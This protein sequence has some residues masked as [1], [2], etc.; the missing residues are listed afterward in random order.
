MLKFVRT[1]SWRWIAGEQ[2]GAVRLGDTLC[3]QE[4]HRVGRGMEQRDQQLGVLNLLSVFSGLMGENTPPSQ[5]GIPH[6]S[7]SGSG[8]H[9]QLTDSEPLVPWARACRTQALIPLP[10]AVDV[11]KKMPV[12][13]CQSRT[14]ASGRPSIC[15]AQALVHVFRHECILLAG[16][17]WHGLAVL[18]HA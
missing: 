13:M 2:L 6:I 5:R 10:K 15:A 8:A 4:S 16:N 7:P 12:G 3:V 17:R 1:G 9:M 18:P 11:E 14:L